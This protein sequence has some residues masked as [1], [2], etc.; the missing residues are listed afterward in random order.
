MTLA[1]LKENAGNQMD[2]SIN[3]RE[4]AQRAKDS[5]VESR[6]DAAKVSLSD[7][8]GFTQLLKLPIA[9]KL[10]KYYFADLLDD[11]N[12]QLVDMTEAKEKIKSLETELQGLSSSFREAS[13]KYRKCYKTP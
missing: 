6:S 13:A 1:D 8:K 2:S 12:Q 9:T 5:S 11:Y 3:N 4:R 7:L 10:F